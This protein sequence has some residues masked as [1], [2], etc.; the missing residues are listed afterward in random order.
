MSCFNQPW[1]HGLLRECPN[2]ESLSFAW[3]SEVLDL[4]EFGDTEAWTCLRHW[5]S[6]EVK[7]TKLG[8]IRG[9][10]PWMYWRWP[11]SDAFEV[12]DLGGV[13][14]PEILAYT[15]AY[16]VVH[17]FGPK[18]GRFLPCNW[19]CLCVMFVWIICIFRGF[20]VLILPRIGSRMAFVSWCCR[21]E[22]S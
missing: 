4:D 5:I 3:W 21:G 11:S 14:D 1:S 19:A 15:I 10:G 13:T 2:S 6:D 12:L 9:V 18:T 8:C 16:E 22:H 17:R 20:H 7:M